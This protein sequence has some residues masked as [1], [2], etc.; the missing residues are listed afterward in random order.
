MTNLLR[1]T[2]L[3]LFAIAIAC[4]TALPALAR[5]LAIQKFD[6]LVTV[7]ADGTIDVSET[8]LVHFTGEWHGIYRT[9]P[10][11]YTTAQGF[12]YSLLLDQVAATDDTG[13]RLKC[14]V[15][16]QGDYEQFKIY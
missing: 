11:D 13:T 16:R 6:S 3:L 1:R 2:A 7:N 9:I 8:I 5:E 12:N 4:A 10:V 14:E 15:S